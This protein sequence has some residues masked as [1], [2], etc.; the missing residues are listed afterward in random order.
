MPKR[1]R[2]SREKPMDFSKRLV[3]HQYL[4][5]LF[6]CDTLEALARPLK[7]SALERLDSDNVSRIHKV[8]VDH[9]PDSSVLSLDDL[10]TYDQHIVVHTR[11]INR[12]RTRPIRWKYFQYLALL[13][14]ELYLDRYFRDPEALCAALNA[15]VARFNQDKRPIDQVGPYTKTDLKKLAFW[16]AT[17]SGKT[18]LMHVH[19]LQYRDYLARFNRGSELNRTILLTPNEGLSKQHRKDLQESGIAVECFDPAGQRR[20]ARGTVEIID[21]H[22]LR[23]QAGDKTV[24]VDSFEGNN[25]VLV[26]EGHRG[27]GGEE[28]MDRRNRLCEQG[29]SFEYSATFGQAMRAAGKSTLVEAYARCVVFDYS[30]RFFHSDGY[31]KDYRILN[32]PDDSHEDR[33][34]LYLTAALLSFYQQLRVYQDRKAALQAFLLERPLW[35]FVGSSVTKT[36]SAR[37]ITDIEDILLFLAGFVAHRRTSVQRIE[38]IVQGQSGLMNDQDMELFPVTFFTHLIAKDLTA[39]AL[40]DDVLR[41]VFNAGGGGVL[42]VQ[43]ILDA[44]GELAV[45]LGSSEPFGVVNVSSVKKLCDRLEAH[46]SLVVKPPSTFGPSLFDGINKP[47]SR[48]HL[49][50]GAKKFIEG[51]SS[52]RVSTMGLMNIGRKEGAQIIQLFGRG[53]RLKGHGFGLKRSSALAGVDVPEGVASLETLNIFGV[54][55]NYMQQFRQ[56]LEEEDL[57]TEDNRVEVVLPVSINLGGRTLKT[58]ALPHE[59]RGQYKQKAPM[60]RLG[61]PP[62]RLRPVVLDAYPRIQFRQSSGV[63]G[64][65][66]VA[67]RKTGSLTAQH[68]AFIDLDAVFFELVKYKSEQGWTSF[69]LT[70]S[71]IE[72]L[73]KDPSWYTLYIPPQELEATDYS[74]VRRWQALAVALLKKYCERYYTFRKDEWER[75]H[76]RY[77]HLSESDGNFTFAQDGGYRFTVDPTESAVTEKLR[78]LR[79]QMAAGTLRDFEFANLKALFFDRHLYQPLIHLGKGMLKVS[80]VALNEGERDFVEHLRHFYNSRPAFFGNRRLYLLRNLSRGRGIGFFEAGNF[81]PDFIV[82]LVEGDTQY[83]TFVDPKGIR[84]LRGPTDPKIAFHQT[85]KQIEQ[86]LGD[87]Q[88]VLSSF[89]I[90]NTPLRA[91]RWWAPGGMTKADFEQHHV[92]FQNE[93]QTTYIETMFRRVLGLAPGQE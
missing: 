86:R 51:W 6:G 45:Q 81:H 42:Q 83:I 82:W 57:P 53:V 15:Q 43:R 78:Q 12:H 29:F 9:L 19:I 24:A 66:T 16:S 74:S 1:T 31:G 84:N 56:Y 39:D 76:L 91:L 60:P 63:R 3:L 20:S 58:L 92:L 32:L 90:S 70:H 50:V 89:I 2:R 49:L 5:S 7:S 10:L 22:K 37:D 61:P 72:A 23:E 18:L 38:R 14:T 80:P 85:I 93:D 55:A 69:Q 28:W 27:A 79:D 46:R 54:R 64:A 87:P 75:P 4:L 17:G 26:D 13:F 71:D 68:L 21:I 67:S 44:P 48:V 36:T 40:F 30:Y 35:I 73:L 65:T 88:V 25:L 59:L 47:A 33:R 34:A 62:D 41:T 52:W 77:Q 11:A 8:L